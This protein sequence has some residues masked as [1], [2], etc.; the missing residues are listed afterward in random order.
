MAAVTVMAVMMSQSQPRLRST[1]VATM[2]V[3]VVLQ[4]S[5]APLPSHPM[6]AVER[7]VMV[8]LQSQLHPRSTVMAVMVMKRRSAS[9]P[10]SQVGIPI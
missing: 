4:A 2:A 7:V 1:M 10:Q 5:Q 3:M 6:V 8:T 9:R